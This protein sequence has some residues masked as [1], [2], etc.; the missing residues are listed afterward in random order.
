MRHHLPTLAAML[1]LSVSLPGPA[2]AQAPVPLWDRGER[3]AK[4]A[5]ICGNWGE[6]P[7]ASPNAQDWKWKTILRDHLATL[8]AMDF[9]YGQ[10]LAFETFDQGLWVTPPQPPPPNGQLPLPYNSDLQCW[11]D[12]QWNTLLPTVSPQ[13]QELILHS[14]GGNWVDDAL[15]RMNLAPSHFVLSA[16]ENRS[17]CRVHTPAFL[18]DPELLSWLHLS[19][20]GNPF[21]HELP[22]RRA[23][24]NRGVV[25]LIWNLILWDYHSWTDATRQGLFPCAPWACQQPPS[26]LSPVT[27]FVLPTPGS[28]YFDYTGQ[29]VSLG[30]PINPA[31][32]S[33][34]SGGLLAS[35]AAGYLHLKSS[36][37]PL[38]Q[39]QIEEALFRFAD[40]I[41][42]QPM[43]VNMANLN[44]RVLVALRL[45][46]E[47]QSQPAR[48]AT[49]MG[50]YSQAAHAFYDPTGGFGGVYQPQ[51]TFR[52][53]GGFDVGYNKV[54]LLH[55]ARLAWLDGNAAPPR[56]RSA[57]EQSFDLFGHMIFPDP[58]VSGSLVTSP[59]AF[60]T[61]TGKGAASGTP[62]DHVTLQGL[63]LAGDA[64]LPYGFAALEHSGWS[65]HAGDPWGVG[66]LLFTICSRFI[67]HLHGVLNTLMTNQAPH[68][69]AF[70]S[71]P[72]FPGNECA[73]PGRHGLLS[74]AYE[75]PNFAFLFKDQRNAMT[76]WLAALNG[77]KEELPFEHPQDAYYRSFDDAFFY[78]MPHRA[79]LDPDALVSLIHAGPVG[80]DAGRGYG[81]GQLSTLWTRDG[82][83]IIL[84]RRLGNNGNGSEP[85]SEW[86]QLP[87]HAV[88][89]TRHNSIA[90]WTS[91]A[92]IVT[93]AVTPTQL[94]GAPSP[95]DAFA[96]LSHSPSGG[97]VGTLNAY[98]PVPGSS[99]QHVRV[100]GQIPAQETGAS[101]LAAPMAYRRDFLVGDDYVAVQTLLGATTFAGPTEGYETIPLYYGLAH[102]HHHAPGDW[103]VQAF[104]GQALAASWDITTPAGAPVMADRVT[105]RRY[106]ST[107]EIVFDQPEP[108]TL[109]PS[110]FGEFSYQSRN[111]LVALHPAGASAMSDRAIRYRI[112]TL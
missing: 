17:T 111:L 70:G 40:R 97:C 28:I 54:N 82:G 36:L 30:G 14:A 2:T 59:S 31:Q 63:L 88:S 87:V 50:L 76:S 99:G 22:V 86:R 73:T 24:V 103:E 80:A 1:V 83:P 35:L 6:I 57:A 8:T 95:Q 58:I 29:K 3:P 48:R 104:L 23:L 16:L 93:P 81:G 64:G 69:I 12:P 74:R 32:Y 11:S 105:V 102:A 68:C 112:R 84:A 91:S 19:Y 67:L 79:D 61:R 106:G 38:L 56:L 21:H 18:Q 10:T 89:F 72:A 110:W 55:L 41:A 108:V 71:P 66:H 107:L 15:V 47:T 51:G 9:D 94:V 42:H 33:E 5:D 100:C 44:H 4:N 39:Q 60:N 92:R 77:P 53:V 96:A 78:A 45:I 27:G 75:T 26:A 109:S 25:W 65:L 13:I 90:D 101:V 20:D 37:T 85:V 46:A 52:D 62:L 43:W 34:E 49:I 98:T 7:R